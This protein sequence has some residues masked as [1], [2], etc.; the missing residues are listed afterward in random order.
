MIVSRCLVIGIIAIT[1]GFLTPQRP[2]NIGTS[3]DDA[4]RQFVDRSA[5]SFDLKLEICRLVGL[6]MFCA[7]GLIL[8]VALM[9]PTFLYRYCGD[10][11]DYG[12][13]V[14]AVMVDSGGGGLDQDDDEARPLP[15]KV[16]VPVT[17]KLTEVQPPR[18]AGQTSM[19]GDV[20]YEYKD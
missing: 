1:A 8:A 17:E 20:M 2:I 6:T 3:T 4:G 14:T 18:R 10:A 11:T 19:V 15:V 12:D 16:A 13:D 7:G 5:A 9:I